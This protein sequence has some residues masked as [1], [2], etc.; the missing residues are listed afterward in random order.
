[1]TIF[2]QPGYI[3]HINAR[4]GVESDVAVDVGVALKYTVRYKNATTENL[5]AS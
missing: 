2:G 4:D 3:L 1:L 5:L